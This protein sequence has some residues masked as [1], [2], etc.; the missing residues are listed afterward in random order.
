MRLHIRRLVVIGVPLAALVLLL[1]L[2]LR[3]N[4]FEWAG[5][6]KRFQ[7]RDA[8]VRDLSW[9]DIDR[10]AET[11][12]HSLGRG[13]EAEKHYFHA[14]LAF[15]R[16]IQES[17]ELNNS[18]T[19]RNGA[20]NYSFDD[21]DRWLSDILSKE[22]EKKYNLN[23]W[24][25]DA[26][27]LD[28]DV[29]D[30][31]PE[32]CGSLKYPKNLPSTSVVITIFNEWPSVVLRTIYSII[33]RTP[34]YLLKE[35][36]LVDDA[37]DIDLIGHG[38][39]K[40]ISAHFPSTLVKLVRL[41][42]RQGLI[43]SR[44]EG[45]HHVTA[46]VV[47]F[48]DGHMEVNQNWL[49]PLLNEIVKKRETLAL[50]QL[51]YIDKNTFQY[52]FYPG[53]RTRYGFRWD[54]QFFETYFRPDQVKSKSNADPLPGVLYVGTGFAVDVKYFKHVGSYDSGMM[55]W[56]GENIEL[57]WR[58]WMCGGQIIHVP[59]S[60]IGHIE[61]NQ[62]YT[63]PIGRLKTEMYNYKRAVEVW[64][65]DYKEYVYKQFPGMET[66]DVGSL[67]ER[68]AIRARLRCHNF[69]WFIDNI[70]PELLRYKEDGEQWGMIKT[71]EGN[72]C[73]DNDDFVFQGPH[74]LFIKPCVF[75]LKTQGF[76]LTKPGQLKT[77]IHCVVAIEKDADLMPFIQNC[78]LQTP[79]AWNY[80]QNNQLVHSSSG[81]C[82]EAMGSDQHKIPVLQPCRKDTAAQK[83]VFDS[84]SFV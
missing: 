45:L 18:S 50:A 53:Y 46:E 24:R 52:N 64:L 40:A 76:S 19:S 58:V 26:I 78:F 73:L 82:L 77:T 6:K 38:L 5:P 20:A 81:M 67:A 54:M 32:E 15:V 7:H 43:R 25:S 75:D 34:S 11:G 17:L 65:G 35:V 61:R 84:K 72:F 56:G 29:P 8:F 13:R 51:D 47:A 59:C 2:L 21:G 79:Q 74:T 3:T 48:L 83:W 66:L 9:E 39:K 33:N 55:I 70:W 62:P 23:I 27:P 16:G 12:V 68:N 37:S 4:T 80:T 71:S 44:L 60:H 63:F 31:R 57:A 10:M 69:T 28:R 22:S 49:Q 42:T 14:D 36:I 1:L 30:S 41:K